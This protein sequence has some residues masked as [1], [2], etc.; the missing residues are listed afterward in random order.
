M[1]IDCDAHVEEGEEAWS[2]LDPVFARKRP[3]TVEF[4]PRI[5]KIIK[6][7]VVDYQHV[8]AL[9]LH[10]QRTLTGHSDKIFAMAVTPD[11]LIVTASTPF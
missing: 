11:D 4:P 2:Y 1:I 9:Q 7:F 3:F 5:W 8:W 6:S 10:C